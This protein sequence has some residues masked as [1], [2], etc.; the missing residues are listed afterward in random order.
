MNYWKEHKTLRMALIAACFAVGMV[1]IVAGWRMT[2]TLGGL[3]LMLVG[4]VVL[5]AALWLYNKVFQDPKSAKK[6]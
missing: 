6:K 5:M 2:G 4:L 3:G 1:L